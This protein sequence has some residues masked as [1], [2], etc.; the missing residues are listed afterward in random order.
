MM[1]T[2]LAAWSTAQ[3]QKNHLQPEVAA[4]LPEMTGPIKMPMKYAQ[5]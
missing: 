1:K 4:I 3:I 2:R 5:K